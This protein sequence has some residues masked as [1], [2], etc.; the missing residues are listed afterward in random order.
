MGIFKSIFTWW[1]GATIGTALNSWLTG[2][3]VGE[4]A[5]GNRYFEAKRGDPPKRRWVIYQGA[6]DASRVPAEWHGWLHHTAEAAP[7]QGLPP[8]REWERPFVPNLTGS[9]LAYR[10]PGALEQGGRRAG[11]TGDYLAWTPGE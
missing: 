1:D 8:A 2:G 3:R 9:R 7:D 6:N 4:D 11:A 10:P 5:F